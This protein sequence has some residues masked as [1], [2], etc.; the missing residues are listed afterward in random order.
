[1]RRL[2]FLVGVLIAFAA[3]AQV[4][5]A[6][7]SIQV[8]GYWSK[9]DKQ[10]YAVVD[11]KY[12]VHGT[13]TAN[14]QEIKYNVDITVIDSTANSYTIEWLYKNFDVTGSD[15]F[16]KS[17]ASIFT[18]VK[19][20]IKTDEMGAFTEVVNWKEVRDEIKKAFGEIKKQYKDVPNIGTILSTAEASLTTKEAIESTAIQDIH[21]FYT[22]HGGKYIL[23]SD[24]ETK[25]VSN[26]IPEVPVDVLM[27]VRLSEINFDDDNGVIRY[28]K[29]FDPKQMTDASYAVMTR[30]AKNSGAKLPKRTE[31]PEIQYVE[32]VGSRV[33]GPSGWIIYSFL[34]KQTSTGSDSEVE[35][36]VIEIL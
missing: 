22:F 36:R 8:I 9:A 24:V 20:I 11:S 25:L 10:S 30:L 21:Q 19:V 31:I 29:E 28:W 34:T 23:N 6:D 13:D 2:F 18:N 33:H 12:K 35:E 27:T 32:T 14:R 3:S 4:N 7:S 15:K 16:T 17:L 1:M 26:G 5:P